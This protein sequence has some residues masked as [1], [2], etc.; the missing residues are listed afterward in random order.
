MDALTALQSRASVSGKDLVAPAPTARELEAAFAAALSAPDHGALKPW[1][2]LVVQGEGQAALGQL[3]VEGLLAQKPDASPEALETQRGKALRGPMVIVVAA[4]V[5]PH[6]KVPAIEQIVAGACAAQALL[7][8][9]HAQGYGAVLVT[10]PRAYDTVVKRGLGLKDEDA[11][12][13]FVHV[14]TASPE[15][16]IKPKSRMTPAEAAR[17]W[18]R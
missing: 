2:F 16:L 6:P 12:I 14:G 17:A 13:G 5:T 9:F 4:V 1:R 11:I 10:G 18:P 7:T 15:R 8:A 3:Y